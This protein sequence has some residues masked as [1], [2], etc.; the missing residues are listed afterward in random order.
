MNEIR[1]AVCNT[2]NPAGSVFCGSCG[3]QIGFE[4]GEDGENRRYAAQLAQLRREIERLTGRLDRLQDELAGRVEQAPWRQTEPEEP[5]ATTPEPAIEEETAA[6]DQQE[7]PAAPS[8]PEEATQPQEP[9]SE[10][11]PEPVMAASGTD[12]PETRTVYIQGRPFEVPAQQQPVGDS[13]ELRLPLPSMPAVDWER[14]LGRNW[15]AIIGALTL[16]LGIGFFLKLSFDNNWIGD[17]GRILLGLG[18][19]ATLLGLGEFTKRRAPIWSQAVTAGG[20]ATIYMSIYASYVLYELIRPDAAFYALGGVVWLAGI[21]AVRYDSRVIGFLGIIGAFI[22]PL[23]LGPELP[24]VRLVLPYIAVVDLGILGVASVRNWRWF[25]ISGWIGSYGLFA[26]G[27]AQYPETDPLLFQAGLTAIFLIFVGAT[28]LFHIKWKR[29]PGS[30]DMALVAVNAMAYFALTTIVLGDAY[31][32]WLWAIAAAMAVMY[33]LIA[34]V[35]YTRP[36][37]PPQVAMIT[38]PIALIFLTVAVPL[39]LTGVWLTT[40]WAAQ[41]AIL[42]WSGFVLGRAP[43]RGFGLGVLALSAVHLLSFPPEVDAANFSIFANDRFGVFVFVTAAIYVAAYLYLRFRDSVHKLET[44]ATSGLMVVGSIL[45]IVALSLEAIFYYGFGSS[46]VVDWGLRQEATTLLLLTLTWVWALYAVGLLVVGLVL[47]KPLARWGGLGLLTVALVKLLLIDSFFALPDAEAYIPGFNPHFI[48]Y[49][50]VLAPTAFVAYAFRRRIAASAKDLREVFRALVAALHVLA[51]WGLS[52]EAIHYFDAQALTG[53]SLLVNDQNALDSLYVTL[54][55]IWALY[56]AALLSVGL[57]RGM[58]LARWGGLALVGLA[59]A[60]LVLFDSFAI[61]PTVE[62]YVPVLNPKFLA[63]VIA[64]APVAAIGYVYRDAIRNLAEREVAAF[65]ALLV[66]TN[67][68][69]VWAITVEAV[70]FFAMREDRLFSERFDPSLFDNQSASILARERVEAMQ[71]VDQVEA[72]LLSLTVIWALYGA[73]LL[74][75]GLWK[76]LALGSMGRSRIVGAGRRRRSCCWIRS[77]LLPDAETY[78]LILQYTLRDQR[79]H[80]CAI[81][82]VAFAF[83]DRIRGL[84]EREAEIMRWLPVVAGALVLWAMSLEA[85]HYFAVQEEILETEQASAMHLTL[86]VLWAIYGIGI[87]VVGFLRDES[88]IRLAGMG[89]LAVPVVKLFVFD[90]FLLEQIY[91]VAAFVTLGALLLATGLIYQRY[92]TELKGLLLGRRPEDE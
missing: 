88:R 35:A 12:E 43:M 82:V 76:N 6:P 15:L 1:C 65:R 79:N 70:H 17:T 47:D 51:V 71:A 32:D 9:V 33:G 46:N 22:A 20:A 23:L 31:F 30:L 38:L 81:G 72:L 62:T 69:A 2:S 40:A 50:M 54:T 48:T 84:P 63:F 3:T 53:G 24:D 66:A 87:I 59:F 19:G 74:A 44:E 68:V 18:A 61:L 67:V 37:A 34:L 89:L 13:G 42:I 10:P 21:L 11:A 56:A 41:G 28:T 78:T 7:E 45:T 29:V 58:S 73:A 83:R 8:E 49:A 60:K 26:A 75:V 57:A 5:V 55:V 52:L 27:Y 14:V 85:I 25:T 16:A 39:G 4:A 77:A 86:T 92:S 90:V 91:R 36:G 80:D 64:A